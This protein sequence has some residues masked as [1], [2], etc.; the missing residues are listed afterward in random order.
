[1]QELKEAIN[2]RYAQEASCCGTLS[3]GGA[4]DLASPQNGEVLIDLG[5]GRGTDV[6]K[7]ALKVGKTGKAI[8]VDFTKEMLILAETNRKKL[9]LDHVEFIESQI[10]SL[11]F[12]DN[13]ADV[14]ISNCTINHSHDKTK[15]YSEIKRVLKSKGRAVV[16]DVISEGQLPEEVVNDPEAWAGC[17]GGAIPKSEYF[18]AISKAGFTEIEILEES[19]PYEKGG[20]M[21]RSITIRLIK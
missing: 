14:I 17:Y 11:P 18:D 3:C 2:V 4:L 15:V 21:V 7:A 5:S 6:L 1:M 8:G 20:V 16:S 9:K 19:S 12:L 10:E 13:F